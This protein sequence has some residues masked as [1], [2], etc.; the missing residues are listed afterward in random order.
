MISNNESL[1]KLDESHKDTS[2]FL[3]PTSRKSLQKKTT[4]TSQ[5]R[6]K[7]KRSDPK[8]STDPVKKKPSLKKNRST[9][10]SSLLSSPK[11][12]SKIQITSPVARVRKNSSKLIANTSNR[13]LKFSLSPKN[14][15]LSPEEIEYPLKPVQALNVLKSELN[16]YEKGEVLKYSEVYF[17]G[18][19]NNKIVPKIECENHGYD[20][21]HTDYLLVKRDHIAYRYEILSLLGK[22]SFGQVCECFD[23]KKKEKVA[24]KVIKNKPK[25]HQ[26]ARIEIKILQTMRECDPDDTK[27]I[28][29][30]K[31][32]FMFRNH[33]C[34]TFELISVNLYEFLRLNSFE[35]ISPSLIKCFAKQ[36]LIS[37]QYTKKLDIVHCD[38]KPENILLVNPQK[39]TIK[40]ID[41]GSSCFVPERLHTYIQSRFYRAPEIILGIPY[42]PAIDMWSL[43]CILVELQTGQPLWPGESE[44]DQLLYIIS[45]LGMP[46]QEIFPL[47]C[48]KSLFFDGTSLKTTKLLC[49]KIIVPSGNQ[50]SDVIKGCDSDFLNFIEKCLEWNPTKRLTPDEALSHPWVKSQ[51]PSSKSSIIS[52]KS[53]P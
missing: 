24:I 16:S 28:I 36:V 31:N 22:G 32:Y 49:G 42:T 9:K 18:T 30:M 25:F 7:T 41:F 21:P 39:A 44:F 51:K 12:S 40:L 17:V 37:L 2:S 35:G 15:Y 50:L 23:H 27:H 8:I 34:I 3:S 10:I 26:Q 6:L 52:K 13:S 11:V 29:R 53:L 47:A 33:V 38:L 43:G 46:P 4:K 5:K 14:S 20:D 48:R 1:P 45:T 19:I